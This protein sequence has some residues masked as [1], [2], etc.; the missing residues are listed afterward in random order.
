MAFAAAAVPEAPL[1]I[2]NVGGDHRDDPGD[3]LG[4]DRLG[5][6]DG[7]LEGEEDHRV[8]Y[9]RG[10]A[11]DRELDQFVVPVGEGPDRARQPGDRGISEG[12][13]G[14]V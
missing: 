14:K 3:H 4:R 9:E 8:D 11:D 5:L 1:P 7:Q 6:E 13:N 2:E 12:H 10:R